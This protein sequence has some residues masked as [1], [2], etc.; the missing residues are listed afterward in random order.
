MPKPDIYDNTTFEQI[1]CMGLAHKYDSLPDN[2]EPMLN[3]IHIWCQ[4]KVW[5]SA[6]FLSVNGQ[7][8]DLIKDFLGLLFRQHSTG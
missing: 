8:I 2:L 1:S 7:K 3:L 6:T 5:Y 4:N